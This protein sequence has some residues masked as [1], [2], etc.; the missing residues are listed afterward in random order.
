MSL[1][2]LA[3]IAGIIILP[4]TIVMVFQ[5]RR[6]KPAIQYGANEDSLDRPLSH[7][8][9]KLTWDGVELRDARY[10]AA[11]VSNVGSADLTSA[12]FDRSRPIKVTISGCE[13]VGAVSANSERKLDA[14]AKTL[15]YGPDLLKSRRAG[16]ISLLV[17]GKPQFTWEL[18]LADVKTKAVDGLPPTTANMKEE[19]R[20][21]GWLG[22]GV[23]SF[24]FAVLLAALVLIGGLIYSGATG[25]IPPPTPT[26]PE[27][28]QQYVSE[29]PFP[30]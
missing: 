1:I 15:T 23:N 17:D 29:V 21:I 2:T 16:G 19:R 18:P 12:M 14:T 22:R 30:F 5:G 11:R 9:L 25:Q 6:K 7:E 20:P 4:L 28:C 24:L 26:I 3:A 13:I 10:V 8:K 27:E